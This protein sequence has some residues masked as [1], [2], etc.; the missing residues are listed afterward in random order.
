MAADTTRILLVAADTSA[1]SGTVRH[2]ADLMRTLPAHGFQVS[3]LCPPGGAL[4]GFAESLGVPVEQAP[5]DSWLPLAGVRAMR[6]AVGRLRPDV[7]HAHESRAALY[8]RLGD[9]EAARR[10][11]WTLHGIEAT[12]GDSAVARIR[13]IGAGRALRSRT[14]RFVCVC[15]ADAEKGAVLG[16]IDPAKSLVIRNGIEL[17]EPVEPGGFRSELGIG[18][19]PLVLTVGQLRPKRDYVTL[20]EAWARVSVRFPS[21][22]LAIIGAG[23][24]ERSLRDLAN[25]R[26][27]AHT[28]RFLEPRPDLRP[29]YADADI[30][31]LSPR[32]AGLPYVVLEAMSHGLPVLAT[33]T[34]GIPEAVTDRVTGL[35]VPPEDPR[36]LAEALMWAIS[37]P[38]KAARLGAAGRARVEHEFG[39]VAM[40]EKVAALYREVAGVGAS[41]R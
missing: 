36:T 41:A 3:L 38:E 21:A 23:P 7:V 8:A 2:V 17:P 35:L 13:R 19:K 9:P 34:D 16:L 12:P 1:T 32:W 27:V 5:V 30:F 6:S 26:S 24:L 18:D 39:L 28:A 40:A 20:I 4:S 31:A 33:A 10:C 37:E 29:A 25:D 14:A 15:E 22:T 11:I